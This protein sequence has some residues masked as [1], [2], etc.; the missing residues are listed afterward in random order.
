MVWKPLTLGWWLDSVSIPNFIVWFMVRFKEAVVNSLPFVSTKKS[1]IL[2]Q[3]YIFQLP[4][5][6]SVYG[7]S[8]DYRGSRVQFQGPVRIVTTLKLYS[9]VISELNPEWNYFSFNP[10]VCPTTHMNQCW[11]INARFYWLSLPN[12]LGSKV[13][14]NP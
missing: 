1:Y 3:T 10:V 5:C 4:V 11:Y 8:M 7:L 6:L 2:K 9:V 12:S 14:G 13:V